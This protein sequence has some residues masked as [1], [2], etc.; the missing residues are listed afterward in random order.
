[1]K[2]TK[3]ELARTQIILTQLKSLG[4][5]GSITVAKA[6]SILESIGLRPIKSDS[7]FTS[8]AGVAAKIA[9][10]QLKEEKAGA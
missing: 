6:T 4:N 9:K 1:M 2:L 7:G 10:A 8:L 3:K 5:E